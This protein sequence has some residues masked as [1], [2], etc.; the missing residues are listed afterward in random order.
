MWILKLLG[1]KE[2][3]MSKIAWLGIFLAVLTLHAKGYAAQEERKN[4][5]REDSAY[6]KEQYALL[7]K[8]STNKD[9]AEWNAWR[10]ENSRE[11]ILLGGADLSSFE[12]AGANLN[13]AHLEGA[14]L[15]NV[16]LSEAQLFG[17]NITNTNLEGANLTRAYLIET[18]VNSAVMTRA[19]LKGSSL[20]RV[21]AEN[22]TFDYADFTNADIE[23]SEM[24]NC[25]FV[26]ADFSYAKMCDSHSWARGRYTK[27]I[28][29]DFSE[30]SFVGTIA[31]YVNFRYSTF[32][33]TNFSGCDLSGSDFW[34][35]TFRINEIREAKELRH[36]RFLLKDYDDYL[37]LIDKDIFFCYERQYKWLLECS[38]KGDLS[39]WNEWNPHS[40][41]MYTGRMIYLAGADLKNLFLEKA[42]LVNADLRG[43]IFE[44]TKLKGAQLDNAKLEESY[45]NYSP[46]FDEASLHGANLRNASLG[47]AT[48]RNAF[49]FDANL[50]NANLGIADFSGADLR[51]AD[52][53]DTKSSA[54]NF[55][56]AQLWEAQLEG[57]D[58]YKCNFCSVDL[59]RVTVDSST[60][61]FQCQVDYE[62][63]FRCVPLDG[64]GIDSATKR[65]LEYNIR[66]KNWNDWYWIAT[67]N[68]Q[69]KMSWK[70]ARGLVLANLVRVFWWTSDYGTSV[71]RI[72]YVFCISV[73]F[74]SFIYYLCPKHIENL[75]VKK[76]ASS[77]KKP[78]TASFLRSMYFTIVTMTTL[79]L[80]DI[81]PSPKSKLGHI[82]IIFQVLC[83]YFLL[84]EFVTYLGILFTS[85]GPFLVYTFPMSGLP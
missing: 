54:V 37:A 21:K 35:A 34:Y 80:G 67:H 53:R 42:R 49:V 39:E 13:S 27:F 66:R 19:R 23:M 70:T 9:I 71:I 85:G 60:R 64:I 62:T 83:G 2:V 50:A 29:R 51:R 22:S 77:E 73:F 38:E 55:S 78:G 69:K 17:A 75:V 1:G 5:I 16:N 52:L 11:K 32:T 41:Y 26:G 28:R 10:R 44:G 57:A 20:L 40:G 74:F 72:L 36:A 45:M 81:H 18:I 6:N 43:A 56:R 3:L 8:C 63:D 30:S 48:F 24:S 15:A 12:L 76:G 82:V 61:F 58:F 4:R 46:C 59:R 31:K 84:A 47:S 33:N 7:R 14:N 68:S 79:G 25:T 65:I